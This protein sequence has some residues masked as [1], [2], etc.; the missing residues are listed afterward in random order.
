M[1]LFKYSLLSKSNTMWLSF[2]F[3]ASFLNFKNYSIFF[4]Y[5][6]SI[7]FFLL[8]M[9]PDSQYIGQ[10]TY[11][12]I[13]L[14]INT[15]INE[16]APSSCTAGPRMPTLSLKWTRHALDLNTAHPFSKVNSSCS[17]SEYSFLSGLPLPLH[18]TSLCLILGFVSTVPFL[19]LIYFWF[20]FSPSKHAW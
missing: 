8:Q 4:F 10:I 16:P 6:L 12:E 19:F 13:F 7:V 14:Q 1:W 9:Y 2:H 11:P 15:A 3:L 17:G 5:P 18:F 20:C